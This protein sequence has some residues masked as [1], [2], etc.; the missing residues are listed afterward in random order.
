MEETHKDDN[1]MACKTK[2]K[3]NKKACGGPLKKK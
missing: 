3:V 1:Y 2:K